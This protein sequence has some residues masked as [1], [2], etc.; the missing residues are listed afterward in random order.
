MVACAIWIGLLGFNNVRDRKIEIAIQR[1]M[2]FQARQIMLLFLS[3][4]LIMGLLGGALGIFAGLG[5]GRWLGLAL[6]GDAEGIAAM[7]LPNPGLLLLALFAAPI[8]TVISGWIPAIIA[9]QQDPVTV[10]RE[11]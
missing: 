7:G 5:S 3:K 9:A 10:L 11:K 2:G 1:A 6:E 8:L 4:S